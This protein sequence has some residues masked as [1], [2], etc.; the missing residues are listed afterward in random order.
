MT[1]QMRSI[2]MVLS[3]RGWTPLHQLE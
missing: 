2:L 1:A 3:K